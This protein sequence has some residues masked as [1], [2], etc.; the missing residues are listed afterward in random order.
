[1]RHAIIENN[2]VTNLISLIPSNNANFSN[3]I[4]VDDIPV[5]FGDEYIDGA[6]HR[7]GEKILSRTKQLQQAQETIA[8]LDA[9][10][11]EATYQNIIGGLE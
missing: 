7:N 2:I 6:F 4:R 3:A 11:L 10:L 8:E 9:A 5:T 1:M